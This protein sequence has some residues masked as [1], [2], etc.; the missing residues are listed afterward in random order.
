[1]IGEPFASNPFIVGKSESAAA[2]RVPV[3]E[4]LCPVMSHDWVNSEYKHLVVEASPKA[5]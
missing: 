4:S 2:P 3:E 5:L 1:M